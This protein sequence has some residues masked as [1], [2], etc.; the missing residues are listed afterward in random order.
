M[1][2]YDVKKIASV[3]RDLGVLSI[4]DNTLPTPL[5]LNPLDLGVDIVIHSN[6]KLIGG[7]SDIIL[8]S[9]CTNNDVL[10]KRLKEIYNS[11]C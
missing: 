4:V 6:S 1:G 9:I 10:Y 3:C 7:H 11:T 8:G 5:L 2:I